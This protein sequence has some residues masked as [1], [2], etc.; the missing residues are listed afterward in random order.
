MKVLIV[1]SVCGTG[2]TG[3]ISTDLYDVLDSKNNE[4][5]IAYGRGEHNDKYKTFKIGTPFDNYIHML[6]TRIF[7]RH[8]FSSTL[9]TK[10]FIDFI[11]KFSPDVIHIHN[12]HGY[13]LNI[14]IF[15]TFL[16]EKYKGRIIWTL[17]DCWSF[18]PHSAFIDYDEYGNLPRVESNKM[19]HK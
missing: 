2:S 1:N 13:Y 3:R 5:V 4:C 9:A 15:F 18:S 7:D 6:N 19:M 11:I 8:G 12:V 17:H 16:K 10:K 14:N